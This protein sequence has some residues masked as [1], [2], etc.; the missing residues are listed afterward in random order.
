MKRILALILGAVL[1]FSCTACGETAVASSDQTQAGNSWGQ[2]VSETRTETTAAP[3]I[4][5][6][7]TNVTDESRILTQDEQ[8]DLTKVL[9]ALI[10][11]DYMDGMQYDSGNGN[12]FWRALNYYAASVCHDMDALSEDGS[13]A[14]FTEDQVKQLAQRLFAETEGLPELPDMGMI[15]RR[16]NG[17]YAFTLGNYG[18]VRLEMGEMKL[19]SNGRYLMEVTL[20]FADEQAG[21]W[22]FELMELDNVLCV[23]GILYG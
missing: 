1:I 4:V 20:F 22:S 13:W 11:C 18:D 2:S 7:V 10:M 23:S 6:T 9:L 17:D 16:E 5:N 15:E 19:S 21:V 8:E 14:E 12:F 3:E